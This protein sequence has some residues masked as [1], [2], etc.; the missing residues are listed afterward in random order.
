MAAEQAE[1]KNP[2]FPLDEDRAVRRLTHFWESLKRGRTYPPM[3]SF[4]P[5]RL[6]IRWDH[7]FL[8]AIVENETDPPFDYVGEYLREECGCDLTNLPVSKVPAETLLEKSAHPFAMALAKRGP[9]IIEGDFRHMRGVKILH[10]SILLPLGNDQQTI[11][12]LFGGVSCC[13]LCNGDRKVTRMGLG[14]MKV[15]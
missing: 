4:D 5:R 8:L 15:N 3:S 9:Y 13:E 1:R 14:P 10:R 11:D 12:Y 6:P 2:V 7:C